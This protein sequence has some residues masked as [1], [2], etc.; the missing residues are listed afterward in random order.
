[1]APQARQFHTAVWTGSTA[2]GGTG[3]MLIWGG[4]P[5][6]TGFRYKPQTDTW[7]PM[8]T[9]CTTNPAQSCVPGNRYGH[10]G[11]WTGSEMIVFGGAVNASDPPYG[12]G[13]RYNPVS[14]AWTPLP[15]AGSTAPRTRH[16]AVWSGS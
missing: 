4:I 9:A 5:A 16:T 1:N 11:V 15:D 12:N 3:E 14:D 8:G 13:A 6:S 7:T 2:N 10:S